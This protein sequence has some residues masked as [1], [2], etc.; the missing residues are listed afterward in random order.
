MFDVEAVGAFKVGR[1]RGV[2]WRWLGGRDR[3][4][5]LRNG[6]EALLNRTGV[7]QIGRD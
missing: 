3:W 4:E 6:R 1:H 5:S 7:L 2:V